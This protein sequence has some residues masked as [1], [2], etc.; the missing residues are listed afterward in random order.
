MAHVAN[1]ARRE[2]GFTL[3]ELLVVIAIISLLV[4][5]LMP[6]LGRARELAVRTTCLSN[7]HNLAL[8]TQI[9]IGDFN[10]FPYNRNINVEHDEVMSH[11]HDKIY[12]QS[13][14]TRH[15]HW[16]AEGKSAIPFWP[17][18]FDRYRYSA[19]TA[20]AMGCTVPTPPKWYVWLYANPNPNHPQVFYRTPKV[21]GDPKDVARYPTYVYRGPSS[22]D[23]HNFNVYTGGQI[24]WAG[25]R[26]PAFAGHNASGQG[27]GSRSGTYFPR[28]SM[29]GWKAKPLFHCPVFADV[30]GSAT[31]LENYAAPHAFNRS[32][33]NR[34]TLL[35]RQ[36]HYLAQCIGWSDGRAVYYEQPIRDG[37]WFVNYDGVVTTDPSSRF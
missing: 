26:D 14:G 24:A 1:Q 7:L 29:V 2:R 33:R 28:V 25:A 4:S 13:N 27:T 18:Y 35:D 11:D 9:Y 15:E 5:I 30:P 17:E 31:G 16:N 6:S 22:V 20:Q 3:I 36:G 8:S 19:S 34:Q 12:M 21:V 32:V 23:D 37:H 10:E